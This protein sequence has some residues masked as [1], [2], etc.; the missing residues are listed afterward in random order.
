[1]RYV[2][3][4]RP[5]HLGTQNLYSQKTAI[6]SDT[7]EALLGSVFN[8]EIKKVTRKDFLFYAL[9]ILTIAAIFAVVQVLN[10]SQLIV[11]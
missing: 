4:I 7:A 5:S 6:S 1:M 3:S 9:E 10:L 2:D 8:F 11:R